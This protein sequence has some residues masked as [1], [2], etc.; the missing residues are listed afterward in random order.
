MISNKKY[1]HIR[2]QWIRPETRVV[3]IV[4]REKKLKWQYANEE[5]TKGELK[6]K[7]L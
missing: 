3:D 6:V 7:V 5:W 1:C 2:I 4:E